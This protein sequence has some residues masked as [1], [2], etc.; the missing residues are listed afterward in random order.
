VGRSVDGGDLKPV[1][2]K[3]VAA[4]DEEL[5]R[6]RRLRALLKQIRDPTIDELIDAMEVMM[7]ANSFTP[8][9]L[10]AAKARHGEPG[11]AE[12][13]AAWQEACRRFVA[14]LTPHVQAGTD[15][16]DPRV[17]DLA[18]RWSAVMDE[19]SGGDPGTLAAIYAKFDDDPATASRGILDASTWEYLKR[20]FA[21]G[22]GR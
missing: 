12:R 10:A 21:V 8:E 22:F 19:L 13:F 9:Q 16:F 1:L 4:V 17:Q 6:L 11:F 3:Q 2:A 14:E 15:P 7:Q 20:A 5:A 18:R